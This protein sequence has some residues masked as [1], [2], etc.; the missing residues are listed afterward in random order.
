VPEICRR[1]DHLPLALELGAAR[2]KALSPDALLTRLERRLPLLV[3]GARDAPERQRTL[4]GAID[5]SYELLSDEEQRLFRGLA[6]FV[7]GCTLEAAEVVC[8]ARVDLLASLVD[9]SLLRRA[10]DRYSML[11]TVREY[12]LE[13]L[14]ESGELE[15]L[16]RRHAGYFLPLAREINHARGLEQFELLVQVMPDDANLYA[17]AEWLS[18]TGPVVDALEFVVQL[19]PYWWTREWAPERAR[20]DLRRLIELLE[21]AGSDVPPLRAA[22]LRVAAAASFFRLGDEPQARLFNAESLAAAQEAGAGGEVAKALSGLGRNQEALDVARRAGDKEA[23]AWVLNA[24]AHAAMLAGDLTRARQLFE[25]SVAILRAEQIAWFLPFVLESLAECAYD[26][27]DLESAASAWRETL[28]IA[29]QLRLRSRKVRCLA[30]LAAI[31]AK[32]VAT[33]SPHACGVRHARCRTPTVRPSH[34]RELATRACS[35]HSQ[36]PR[37]SRKAVAW[38]STTQSSTPSRTSTDIRTRRTS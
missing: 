24:M 8:E 23:T 34:L 33:R 32:R 26:Q 31:A 28:G 16:K 11:A 2:V 7:G 18:A 6:V 14:G 20:E 22:A 12:A 27:D 17:A 25:E 29:V 4:R 15:S 38:R 37:R 36:R 21:R 13:R 9:K 1:L 30:G 35:R 5:W 10:G 3:G 19:E